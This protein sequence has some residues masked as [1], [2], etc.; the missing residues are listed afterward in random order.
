MYKLCE[1]PHKRTHEKLH[2]GQD[3]IYSADEGYQSVMKSTLE[4]FAIPT[5]VHEADT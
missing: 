2:G 3:E 5:S 4:G 1:S